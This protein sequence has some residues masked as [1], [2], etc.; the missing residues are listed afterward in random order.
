MKRP[1]PVAENLQM[2]RRIAHLIASRFDPR[3]WF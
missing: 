1:I 2:H 3:P